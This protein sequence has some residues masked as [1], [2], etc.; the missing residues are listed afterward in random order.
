[1]LVTRPKEQSEN[2]IDVLNRGGFNSVYLPMLEIRGVAGRDRK[3]RV[4]HELNQLVQ[5]S[6][7]IFISS[8]A[9]K[10]TSSFIAANDIDWPKGLPCV[11]IGAATEKALRAEGWRIADS[12]AEFEDGFFGAQDSESLLALEILNDIAGKDITLIRGVGGRQTITDTLESR[13]ANVH[14]CEV[15]ERHCPDFSASAWRKKLY[16]VLIAS[17]KLNQERLVVDDFND[18]AKFSAVS[19]ITF[20]SG[21]TLNNFCEFLRQEKTLYRPID[22]LDNTLLSAR[23]ENFIAEAKSTPVVVPSGRV[24]KLAEEQGFVDIT[25]A[26]NAGAEAICQSLQLRLGVLAR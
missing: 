22:G 21:E 7:A 14:C 2:L 18:A 8:N 5:R 17:G 24:M 10:W 1:M 11:A 19:A 23:V 16:D 12:R 20:A 6:Y 3:S 15:Y 25:V 9:V 4:K 26:E 13:G